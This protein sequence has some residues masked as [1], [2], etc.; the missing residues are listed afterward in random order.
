M[1]HVP[2]FKFGEARIQHATHDLFA[3]AADV[4]PLGF[5]AETSSV[6]IE[7]VGLGLQSCRLISR[8]VPSVTPLGN[9]GAPHLSVVNAPHT[10]C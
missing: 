1:D 3:V 9:H 6:L 8:S 4:P 10:G 2:P 5:F 7:P